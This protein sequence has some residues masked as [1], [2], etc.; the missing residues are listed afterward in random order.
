MAEERPASLRIPS[1]RDNVEMDS[2]L[3]TGST[4]KLIKQHR[5]ESDNTEGGSWTSTLL[6]QALCLLWLAPILALLILNIRGHIIGAS[7]WCPPWDPCWVDTYNPQQIVPQENMARFNKADHNLLGFLQLVAKA[8]EV[9]FNFIACLL[10]YV[11]T[12]HLAEQPTGLPLRYLTLPSE[13]SDVTVLLDWS[14]WSSVAWFPGVS[15]GSFRDPRA[16][17]RL[18]VL[19]AIFL[20]ILC[21]LMGPATAVLVLPTLGWRETA[22]SE[23]AW[24]VSNHSSNPPPASGFAF[25][26]SGCTA[27][28][29]SAKKYSCAAAKWGV[30]LDGWISTTMTSVD[31]TPGYMDW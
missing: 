3:S 26:D 24:V 1:H 5:V 31:E 9:W 29:F 7:A 27:A 22:A 23:Q 2:L 21:N 8:L 16:R 4:S 6:I 20:C 13:F 17:V 19:L 10:M 30:T 15:S 18:Y 14:F 25:T 11:L 12:V 28:D